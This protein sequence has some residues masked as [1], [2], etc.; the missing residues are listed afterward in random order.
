M[1]RS[2]IKNNTS[3]KIRKKK[4]DPPLSILS[5]SDIE[6][7]GYCPMSWWLKFEGLSVSNEKLT[8]GTLD[9]EKLI[10]KVTTI[11]AHEKETKTSEFN[12]KL[13]A[14]VATILAINAIVI[15]LPN[16]FFRNLLIYFGI[17]WV[18]I[19]LIYF[20]YNLIQGQLFKSRIFIQNIRLSV[21]KNKNLEDIKQKRST[22][23][24][25]FRST[26]Q[27]WKRTAVWVLI[28]AGGFAFNGMSLLQPGAEEILSRIYL[29]SALLWLIGTAIILYFVLKYEEKMRIS[30]KTN[31]KSIDKD[32]KSKLTESEKLIIAF[33]VV[34][35]LFAINGLTIQ[36]REV[37]TQSTLMGQIIIG[38]AG[39]WLGASFVF[40]YISFQS[41]IVTQTMVK[42]FTRAKSESKKYRIMIE[43][44]RSPSITEQILSYNWPILFTIVSVI[45]GINSIM[46]IYAM[47]FIGVQSEI[48]SRFLII[49]SLIWL[50]GSFI[51]LYDV[52]RNTQLA[53]EL[54]RLHGIYKGKIEYTDGMDNSSKLLY[55]GEFGLRG[56]PDYI[57]KINKKFVPVEIKT[58]KIPK[59]PHFS[60]IIQ[61]AAYCLLVEQNY[62]IRPPYGIISYSK[63]HKHKIIYDE[64]LEKLLKEKLVEMR[65]CIEVGVAHRNHRRKGKCLSCSRR[66]SCPEK[67][68]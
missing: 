25:I 43:K 29:V 7:Y 58:G 2:P 26:P 50:L 19:A 27:N 17:F 68:G 54:R 55:S 47:N 32:N 18:V 48:L 12:I 33:A 21:L 60:H 49:I 31:E 45:L 67:L 62:R 40:F 39:L 35:S 3:K 66:D 8:K 30:N 13:F 5:A 42:E 10:K 41:G 36:H 37:I 1:V 65:T 63:E 34:A 22:K 4:S 57:V 16:P 53:E 9:H 64:S 15:L 38:L 20:V 28:I 6:R 61:I 44:I 51:F 11:E 46:I 56:K 23:G 14:F 24:S 59:G 52:L